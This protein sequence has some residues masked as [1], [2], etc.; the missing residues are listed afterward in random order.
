MATCDETTQ[1]RADGDG[2][3]TTG[4]GHS[5]HADLVQSDFPLQRLEH[6]EAA[7]PLKIDW[8]YAA[9]VIIL[10]LLALL[11]LVPWFFS[12]TG[13]ALAVGGIFVFGMLG[14]NLGYHRLLTHRGFCCP[15]WLERFFALLGVCCLEYAPARW[16]AI[17]RIH[18]QHSD[19]QPD[20]H[21]PLV[22]FLWGHVGWVLTRSRDH[23][24]LA[25]HDR[26]ATEL[27]RDRF[28][29]RLEGIVWLIT[30]LAHAALFFLVGLA[31]GWYS[32]GEY[33]GG[34]QF[35]LSLLVWGVF[36][37]TVLQWHNTWS[38]NSVTHRWGYRNY[39]TKENSRN[40]LIV[41]LLTH[42]EGWHNNHHAYPVSAAHGHRW[43]EFDLTYLVIRTLKV[44]GLVWDVKTYE[45]TRPGEDVL[46]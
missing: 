14:I 33:L 18:H 2:E 29:L 3:P 1:P 24:S 46:P 5:D 4:S 25:S 34:V 36:V 15:K 12:W 19:K 38:V 21:S 17:H 23:A 10:H 9:G 37:R 11:A 7:Q 40:N 41:G 28:Y 45:S 20:P 43:W 26:Y 8:Q 35:G 44:V 39:D 13:V 30:Y 42:G 32:S 6:P 27:L 31:I 22:S 16:V